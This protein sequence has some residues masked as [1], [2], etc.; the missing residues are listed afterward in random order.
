MA[1]V[2]GKDM[3]H[4]KRC[5]CRECAAIIE[6]TESELDERSGTDYSGTG[7]TQYRLTCPNCGKTIVVRET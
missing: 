1:I 6:F 3:A 2:V 4:V 5:T 7:Y